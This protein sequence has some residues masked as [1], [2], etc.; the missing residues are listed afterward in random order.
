MDEGKK[1]KGH[2][3]ADVYVFV[4]L[5]L[6][7][8]LTLYFSNSSFIIDFR[9][10]GLSFFAGVRGGIYGISSFASRTVLSVREL[11]KLREE[12][13]ELTR[14]V[15]EYEKL[16]RSSAEIRQENRRLRE[17]LGFA[18]RLEYVSVAAEIIGR[19]PDNLFS[20]FVINKGKRAGIANDMPVIA[21]QNGVQGLVGKVIQTG[22]F[23]SLVM[24]V[25]DG[26]SYIPARLAEARYEGIAE[27]QGGTE[28]PL[29]MRF[30][31]KR[32][33]DEVN[34]GDVVITSGIGGQNSVYAPG[35][36]IGRVSRILYQE[37]EI[38]MNLEVESAVDF[39]RLEHIFVIS[40]HEIRPEVLQ[41]RAEEEAE[42]ARQQAEAEKE[43]ELNG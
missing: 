15:S 38:S 39:S 7:S 40:A 28:A 12:Y 22:Q 31:Q 26:S 4:V 32:A 19:D 3:V 42:A 36:T 18:E 8:F 9:D 25:Y 24:P 29:L 1:Q 35:I 34:I 10:L 43:Q 6:L 14:R 5:T 21:Y 16:E 2:A 23:E 11:A 13:A 17:L 33:R 41:K 27:G 30:V 20:A 37:N